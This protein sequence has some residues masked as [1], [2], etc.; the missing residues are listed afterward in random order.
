MAGNG[1]L[2]QGGYVIAMPHFLITYDLHKMDR[3]YDAIWSALRKIGSSARVLE[4]VW[5]VETSKPINQIR[6]ALLSADSEKNDSFLIVGITGPWDSVKPTYSDQ[7][8]RN[9]FGSPT[10]ASDQ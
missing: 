2:S 7:F 8:L 4:S 9:W 10:S 1:R 3:D 5:V 6:A